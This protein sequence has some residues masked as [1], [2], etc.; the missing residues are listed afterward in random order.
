MPKVKEK[1][2]DSIFLD[3]D[4]VVA[5]ARVDDSNHSKAIELQKLIDSGGA[6][7]YTSDFVVGEIITVLSQRSGV[8]KAIEIGGQIMS[9]DI[10]II[11]VSKE[12]MKRALQKFSKQTSKNSRF[13]DMVNMVLMDEL[14]ID[15]IFSFDEHYPKNGYKLLGVK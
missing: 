9:G 1:L 10:T 11:Y 5:L 14:K 2:P 7:I 3:T 13:T 8:G 6:K 4:A 15:T 12:Q